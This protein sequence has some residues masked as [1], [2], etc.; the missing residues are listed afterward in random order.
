MKAQH[1][2]TTLI[3]SILTSL[4]ASCNGE[5]ESEDRNFLLFDTISF[6]PRHKIAHI[7]TRITGTPLLEYP[8]DTSR[9]SYR[10]IESSGMGNELPEGA[11][12][13]VRGVRNIVREQMKQLDMKVLALI[14]LTLSQPQVNRAK[15]SLKQIQHFFPK[16]NIFVTFMEDSMH[17]SPIIPLMESM[18]EED[19]MSVGLESADK[20]LYRNVLN[21]LQEFASDSIIE[22]SNK[23]FILFSD[24]MVWG[25]DKP[26]DPDHFEMQQALLDYADK[27]GKR[28][29]IFFFG[30]SDEES[31][32]AETNTTMQLICQRTGGLCTQGFVL[33]NMHDALCAVHNVKDVD[34]Q[35]ELEFPDRRVF[36]GQNTT[37]TLQCLQGDSLVA[38]GKIDYL[39]G[40]LFEPIIVNGLPQSIFVFRGFVLIVFLILLCYVALQ[41]VVPYVRHR[42]FLRKYVAPYTG[43]GMTISGRLVGDHCYFC[44]APFERGDLVVGRCEHSMHKECWDENNYHCPEHG[45]HCTEGSHYYNSH[46]PF[47]LA[48]APFY[49]QWVIAGM[50]AA[51]VAWCFFYLLP[52]ST[53]SQILMTLSKFVLGEEMAEQTLQFAYRLPTYG[54]YAAGLLVCAISVLSRHHQPMLTLIRDLTVRG[55][56]A[57][58]GGYLCFFID[59]LI[60][61]AFHIKAGND[62]VSI[63]ALALMTMWITIVASY[64]TAIRVNRRLVGIAFVVCV[65]GMALSTNYYVGAAADFRIMQLFTLVIYNILMM[66][67]MAYDAKRSE[68]YFL[69]VEGSVK[70]TDIALY[71]WMRNNTHASCTIGKSVDCHLQLSWDIDGDVAPLHAEVKLR[72]AHPYLLAHEDGVYTSDGSQLHVGQSL[73]LY[74]GTQFRI[75][76]T[77][78]TYIEKDC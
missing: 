70:T 3:L 43:A 67:A 50:L 12:P 51:V 68:H 24:G 9:T 47:S 58:V 65:L 55:L 45:I 52:A 42:I 30:L 75:G 37:L 44:K 53:K 26:M 23:T 76:E 10:V 63:L 41:L 32:S 48:N 4:F 27:S 62:L 14:D 19:F 18:M 20:Y 39:L 21:K 57:A 15:M 13:K 17:I 54:F 1:I 69:R 35:F 22:G 34:L 36:W 38:Y 29:P 7:N 40:S 74:H 2:L 16:E 6:M 28:I 8:D 77:T 49:M 60:C 46:K 25:N 61:V 11:R 64:N 59:V 33:D 78:F 56:L 73:R 5:I 71:K 66:L 72:N 31:L